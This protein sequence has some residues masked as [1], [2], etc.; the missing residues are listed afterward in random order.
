MTDIALLIPHYN[1][2][3]GLAKSL[4]SIDASENLDIFIIDDG[5]KNVF[6]EN[7]V[8]ASY[9]GKGNFYFRYLKNNQGIEHAL[10]YGLDEIM[11]RQSYKYIARLDCGDVCL[12]ER[13]RIQA[14]FLDANPEVKLVSSNILCVDTDGKLLYELKFPEKSGEIRKRMYVNSMFS[15]PG[16]M[17]RADVIQEVG[18]Y[19]TRYKSAEDYAFFFKIV[20][21]F[22][23]A[24]IQ[25]FLLKYE[26]N[27]KGISHSKRKQQVMGRI[28]IVM[29]NFYF[30]FWPMYGILRNLI[31]YIVPNPVLQRI[32]R[33]KK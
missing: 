15:H 21:R 19:P 23:T 32:K 10:N 22:E 18:K 5:S 9:G 20:R 33:W 17:Y 4:A 31:L 1:N 3:D 8:T 28:K 29:D 6:D 11:D 27:P 2:P 24:N 14:D 12:G 7:V 30:G 13:F 25:Q 16:S 26:I